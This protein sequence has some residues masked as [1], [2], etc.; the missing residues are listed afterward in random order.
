MH[1]LIIFDLNSKRL[2]PQC[3]GMNGFF[4]FYFWL[5]KIKLYRLWLNHSVPLC[6]IE[7]TSVL[8]ANCYNL[9]N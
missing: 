1:G 3:K 7:N 9:Y 5:V 2:K 8:K 4:Y 6:K